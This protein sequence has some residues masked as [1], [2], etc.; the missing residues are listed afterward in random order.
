MRWL[1]LACLLLALAGCGDY[2][3]PFLGNPGATAMRLRQPPDPRLAI[4]TPGTALLS[5]G[6]SRQFAVALATRLQQGAVPAYAQPA[7]P[8][9]WRLLV[10]AEDRGPDIV[11]TY[12]VL[13]PQGQPQGSVKGKPIQAAAWATADPGTLTEAAADAAPGINSLLTSI[14]N[15][16]MRADPHSLY[17]RA[18]KVMVPPVTGAPGDGD[19]VL[20]KE[21]RDK[22]AALGPQVQTTEDGA[23]FIV[24]GEV[25]LVPIAGGQQRVEI[26][27]IIKTAKGREAGRVVQ[28]ND[29]PAGTLDHYWGDVAM[30]V[31]QQASGGVNEVIRRQSGHEPATTE[32]QPA[33][34]QTQPEPP[35]AQVN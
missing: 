9:D 17:N 10:S 4:P 14:E 19:T 8:T 22:L 31:A 25:R 11:P 16:L 5:D 20:T 30:V 7:Q 6:A 29:I 34:Q 21:M 13:N 12:T 23:D 3:E 1:L 32:A 2:P 24:Q 27:W 35:A 26:Q 18:A 15:G 33:A 28:L